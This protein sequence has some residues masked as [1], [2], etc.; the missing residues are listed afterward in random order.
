MNIWPQT[1]TDLNVRQQGMVNKEIIFILDGL[2]WSY[3][4]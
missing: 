2:S 3:E 1:G 4:K